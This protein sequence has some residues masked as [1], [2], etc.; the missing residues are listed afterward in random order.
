MLRQSLNYIAQTSISKRSEMRLARHAAMQNTPKRSFRSRERTRM[1]I[2]PWWKREVE[3]KEWQKRR[4]G[5]ARDLRMHAHYTY[6]IMFVKVWPREKLFWHGKC[7]RYIAKHVEQFIRHCYCSRAAAGARC[8]SKC[9]PLIIRA[10]TFRIVTLLRPLRM[11]AM[12]FPIT[13]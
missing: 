1:I 7:M 8:V 3:K 9:S 13:T 4:S 10:F 12:R 11:P 5:G 6:I 2:R